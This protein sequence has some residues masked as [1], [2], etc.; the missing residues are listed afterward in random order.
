MML[1]HKEDLR[2]LD[3]NLVLGNERE[4]IEL[5]LAEEFTFE[6]WSSFRPNLILLANDQDLCFLSM[7]F[8]FIIAMYQ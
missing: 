2:I 4:S 8:F 6:Y 7:H 1:L 3:H 5:M